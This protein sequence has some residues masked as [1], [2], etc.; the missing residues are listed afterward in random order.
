MSDLEEANE[1][2]C[3][4]ESDDIDYISLKFPINQEI[5]QFRTPF[6][7][8]LLKNQFKWWVAVYEEHLIQL[9]NILMRNIAGYKKKDCTTKL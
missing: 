1:E 5:Q 8:K 3:D 4:Y 7:T 6:L 9:F 2:N